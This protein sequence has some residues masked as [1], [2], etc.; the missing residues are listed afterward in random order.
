MHS[1]PQSSFHDSQNSFS[2][3]PKKVIEVIKCLQNFPTGLASSEISKKLR[4][5]VRNSSLS[6]ILAHARIEAT[7]KQ[8]QRTKRFLIETNAD[9]RLTYCSKLRVWRAVRIVVQAS[10]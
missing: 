9:V 10:A 6:A 2:R 7:R 4:G 1:H 3:T 5:E 8:I